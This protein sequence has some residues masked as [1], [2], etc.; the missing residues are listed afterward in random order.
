[1]AAAAA[2][3]SMPSPLPTAIGIVVGLLLFIQGVVPDLVAVGLN[4]SLFGGTADDA[5]IQHLLA[6]LREKG[7]DVHTHPHGS[8]L[9]PLTVKIVIQ[10]ARDGGDKEYMF[11]G[12]DAFLKER[13]PPEGYLLVTP[14]PGLL[15]DDFDSE[16][17]E[18]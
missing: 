13:N 17:E 6:H 18:E 11:P 1:M 4:I 7:H 3:C 12:V 16:R 15:D 9:L 8:L 14:I 5:G 2:W 10:Q